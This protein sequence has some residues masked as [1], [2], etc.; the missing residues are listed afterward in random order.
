MYTNLFLIKKCYNFCFLGSLFNRNCSFVCKRINPVSNQ[1]YMGSC[2]WL[3]HILS[4]NM[5]IDPSK[6]SSPQKVI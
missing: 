5:S 6:G 2:W 3:L 4:C 1:M